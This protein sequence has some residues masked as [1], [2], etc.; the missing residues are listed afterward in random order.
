MEFRYNDDLKYYKLITHKSDNDI[1]CSLG[2]SRMTLSRWNKSSELSFQNLENI[3]ELI[4]KEG[5]YIN[6][7]K[8]EL[9]KS[10]ENI[11]EIIL[12]HGAKNE[13]IGN[14]SVEYS[15]AK[16]DFGKGFYL[17]TSIE[18]AAAFISTYKESSVYIY[19]LKDLNNIKI[20]EYSVNEDWMLLIAYFRGNL[21]EYKNS[22]RIKALLE[23]LEGVDIV[24]APIADN[25]MYSIMND[26]INGEITNSQCVYALSANRL[27][28]QYVILNDAIIENNL[29]FLERCYVCTSEK[30]K[31]ASEREVNS[32][33]GRDKVVLA[34]RQFAGKGKYIEELLND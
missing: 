13:I 2:I 33:L 15:G 7:L 24:I 1:A 30:E 17:G 23:Q 32:K 10:D 26:F 6:K 18:Q 22:K 14:P 21:E 8:E 16:K 20:R 12:F 31:Y 27:G 11:N 4:Y 19:K 29:E 34:K 25:T 28:K 3:Y 5:I 9:Y